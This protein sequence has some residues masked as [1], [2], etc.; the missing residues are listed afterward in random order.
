MKKPI[1]FV[2]GF[3]LVI[4]GMALL[5]RHWQAAVMVFEGVVPA[6]IAVFGLVLMFAA[7]LKK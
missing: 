2:A 5:L 7:S 3:V 6:A 1:L 4:L